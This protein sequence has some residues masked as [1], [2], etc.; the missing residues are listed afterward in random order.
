MMEAQ[1]PKPLIDK[2][3]QRRIKRA[4]NSFRK[5]DQAEGDREGILMLEAAGVLIAD[6]EQALEESADSDSDTDDYE[7]IRRRTKKTKGRIQSTG[8]PALWADQDSIQIEEIS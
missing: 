6:E 4:A 1:I 7:G 8:K 2:Q 3:L 5:F